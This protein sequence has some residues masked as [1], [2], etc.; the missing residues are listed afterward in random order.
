MKLGFMQGRLCDMVNGKIQAFPEQEWK[1]EFERAQDLPVEVIEW[2]LDQKGL[3]ENPLMTVEGRN[4]IAHL[5]KKYDLTVLSITGDCFMQH[6]FYKATGAEQ[7]ALLSDLRAIIEAAGELNIRYLMIPL[8]DNGSIENEAMADE[9]ARHLIALRPL[10]IDRNM[11]IL[12]ESDFA[13]QP[14][15]QF[16]AK[17]PEDAFGINYDTGNSAALGYI[18]SEELL[19]YGHRVDNVHIKDRL[20][21][22]T[23]VPLG[24]GAA[25][26]EDVFRA[27]KSISFDGSLILQT[28]RAKDGNHIGALSNYCAFVKT[29]WEKY[30]TQ[31]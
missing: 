8:V 21:K 9:C 23:T 6:P 5:S 17:F 26:F 24:E 2:T 25:D 4:E 18:A 14:L 27:L 7:K 29:W 11:K 10:L 13:P 22:G 1:L 16:I 20:F 28:A 30:A 31:S 15:A 3:Y 19:Y 12:F